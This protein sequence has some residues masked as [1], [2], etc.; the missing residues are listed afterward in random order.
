MEVPYKWNSTEVVRCIQTGSD[1][2]APVWLKVYMQFAIALFFTGTLG[3]ISILSQ[4]T[5]LCAVTQ[6][7]IIFLRN[8]EEEFVVRDPS[9]RN[10]WSK[11]NL[12]SMIFIRMAVTANASFFLVNAI[13]RPT[14]PES[15]LSI[16]PELKN[17]LIARIFHSVALADIAYGSRI[18]VVVLCCPLIHFSL[19][20]L[21][22]F[23]ELGA[24]TGRP[25]IQEMEK[26]IRLG[27]IAKE[28]ESIHRITL[29]NTSEMTESIENSVDNG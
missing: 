13:V 7:L 4:R 8:Y 21:M 14:S 24:D 29:A 26:T 17:C 28:A 27:G 15:V 6:H 3:H 12:V 9:L 10:K 22:V 19:S 20:L 16:W 5:N 2:S 23:Q 11:I 25:N 1:Q 18:A